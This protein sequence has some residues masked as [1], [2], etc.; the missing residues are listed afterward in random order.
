MG[1]RYRLVLSVLLFFFTVTNAYAF[2]M[3][4]YFDSHGNPTVPPRAQNG[5]RSFRGVS[6]Y[7]VPD[8]IELPEGL[9]YD[10]Y[11]VFGGPLIEGR[12][13]RSPSGTRWSLGISYQ[14]NYTYEVDE[15]LRTVRA[16]I[17]ISD[18][19]VKYDITI[20]LPALLDDSSLNVVEKRLWKNYFRRLLEREKGKA[21]IIRDEDTRKEIEGAVGE[22]KGLSFD[23]TDDDA[24][25]HSVKVFLGE[26]TDKIGREW[27][28]KIGEKLD[29]YDR[30][31]NRS[32]W[33]RPGTPF[34][35]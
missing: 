31:N 9:S 12:D 17:D 4:R 35:K 14:Y 18:V 11:P 33:P 30:K 16:T 8:G 10:Y 28:K 21:E 6:R 3:T 2:T 1:I 20:T 26:E 27:V 23:Y 5:E 13:V 25:E 24:I 29:A 32:I 19:S 22:I 34:M 15:E 7:A